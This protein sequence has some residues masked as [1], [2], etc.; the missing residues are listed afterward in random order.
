MAIAGALAVVLA[1]V[2][3]W[4]LWPREGPPL[5]AGQ[6]VHA[7][8]P[9]AVIEFEVCTPK[10]SEGRAGSFG[11]GGDLVVWNEERA[12]G[13][14]LYAADIRLHERFVL[15]SSKSGSFLREPCVAGDRLAWVEHREGDADGAARVWLGDIMAGSDLLLSDP[16]VIGR[17]DVAPD[18]LAWLE[19]VQSK[20]APDGVDDRI[21]VVDLSTGR[22]SRVPA[23]AGPKAALA[24]TSDMVAWAATAK[25]G[26][27][28]S[29][30]WVYEFR[31]G[32][33]LRVA[34]V[35]AASVDVSQDH[36]VWCSVAGNVFAYDLRT[37]KRTTVCAAEGMQ[38][39]CRIDGDL[40]VW[41]DG[42]SARAADE[43]GQSAAR[44]DIYAYDLVG[45]REVPIC[46]HAAAQESPR[47][48]GDTV[49]WLDDRGGRWSIRGAVVRL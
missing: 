28:S 23:A 22:R 46:T 48:V 15:R 37:R 3:T 8:Q 26:D 32:K 9:A 6:A 39:D 41:W 21:V 2:V 1:L 45:R 20:E 43:T 49:V 5:P 44:G 24:V 14:G 29:G 42:R 19:R 4:A 40:V 7:P 47:V 31:S 35:R 17:F 33:A 16:I 30:V 13:G 18:T 11:F 10:W 12:D 38:A 34:D 25:D 27:A 36:V